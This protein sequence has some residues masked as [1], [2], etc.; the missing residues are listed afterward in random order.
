MGA[1]A[2]RPGQRVGGCG[3]CLSFQADRDFSGS[4]Q[5]LP[6]KTPFLCILNVK[7]VFRAVLAVVREPSLTLDNLG[8]NGS[9]AV[10][11][12]LQEVSGWPRCILCSAPLELNHDE[13]F[14]IDIDQTGT[15]VIPG[16]NKAAQRA[17]RTSPLAASEEFLTS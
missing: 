3:L 12:G 17:S 8:A 14:S 7:A 10:V 5:R 4:Q 13:H 15:K 2:L 6:G 11:R 16:K 1:P 9:R